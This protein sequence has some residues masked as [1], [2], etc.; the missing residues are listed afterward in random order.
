[1]RVVLDA[2]PVLRNSDSEATVLGFCN[3]PLP[4]TDDVSRKDN[5]NRTTGSTQRSLT[6]T[7]TRHL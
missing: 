6:D 3:F 2:P 4:D 7:K 1:M 5:V